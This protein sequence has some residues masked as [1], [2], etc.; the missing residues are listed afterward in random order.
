VLDLLLNEEAEIER[1]GAELLDRVWPAWRE[2][3]AE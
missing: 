1:A 3:V 2:C